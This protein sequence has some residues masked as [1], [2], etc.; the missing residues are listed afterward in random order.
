MLLF[1]GGV[2]LGHH[3]LALSPTLKNPIRI[4]MSQIQATLIQMVLCSSSRSASRGV[5]DDLYLLDQAFGAR[6]VVHV[7]LDGVIL[8][9]EVFEL[10]VAFFVAFFVFLQLFNII[11]F[12]LPPLASE[13]ITR[14]LLLAQ[15]LLQLNNL[16]ILVKK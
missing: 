4:N 12:K 16:P 14:F 3:L 8:A 2:A 1:A 9:D 7:L 10:V 11:P 15:Q 13:L 6:L 5:S